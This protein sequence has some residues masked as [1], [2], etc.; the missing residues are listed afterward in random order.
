MKKEL[1]AE[2]AVAYLKSAGQECPFCNSTELVPGQK[3]N[4]DEGCARQDV[5]CAGCG[6]EWTDS[7][8]LGAMLHES[9]AF[10]LTDELPEAPPVAAKLSMEEKLKAFPRLVD[11]LKECLSALETPGD[12]TD[13]EMADVMEEAA[14]A[15]RSIGEY[16]EEEAESAASV[17]QMIL[18][19]LGGRRFIAMTGAK[20]FV[21]SESEGY[22]S[23]RL[24]ARFA[25]N[26]INRVTITLD[27][28]DTYT[29][30]AIKC[31]SGKDGV[32]EETIEKHERVYFDNLQMMFTAMTGLDT[33]L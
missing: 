12:L 20:D 10:D 21:D 1:T 29:I 4:I 30:E 3:V 8:H 32:K 13:T 26:G 9:G 31:S 27:P 17:S 2:S 14:Y 24:P 16:K 15:L 22:L 6:Q 7:Y 11:S 18:T 23:F 28:S 19:Q 5:T 33:H 25:K